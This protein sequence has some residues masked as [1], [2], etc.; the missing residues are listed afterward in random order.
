[1]SL[2][3]P[4]NTRLL[5]SVEEAL[6]R[7]KGFGKSMVTFSRGGTTHERIGVIERV[8]RDAES[9]RLSGAHHASRIVPSGIA[10][11]EADRSTKMK[12]VFYPRLNFLDAAGETLFAVV[13][14]EGL[15]PFNAS[16]AGCAEE[17]VSVKETKQAPRAASSSEAAVAPL[18]FDALQLAQQSGTEVVIRHAGNGFTQEWRGTIGELRPAMGFINIINPDFHL[19]LKD[20]SLSAWRR[21]AEAEG[22]EITFA[23]IDIDGK[24][25]GLTIS[26]E[27]SA[28]AA[29]AENLTKG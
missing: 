16:L 19:H 25:T 4:A 13:G 11:I 8:E 5:V 14:F 23:A 7:A 27:A 22:R 18:V 10:S 29:Q 24:P 6:D 15:E 2:P 28:F 3:A 17:A 21:E 20:G 9:I 1:M 26:G 12:D